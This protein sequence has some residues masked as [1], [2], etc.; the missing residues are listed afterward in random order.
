MTD[1]NNSKNPDNPPT[2]DEAPPHTDDDYF[3]PDTSLEQIKEWLIR[4]SSGYPQH[5][6][7][8]VL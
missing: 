8:T 6:V 5:V 4:H 3:I 2:L 7:Y 1:Y